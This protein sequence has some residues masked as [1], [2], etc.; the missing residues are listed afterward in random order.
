MR[1]TGK[2]AKNKPRGSPPILRKSTTHTA[3]IYVGLVYSI[4]NAPYCGAGVF[5]L[6]HSRQL[7]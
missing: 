6:G 2:R 1:L 5:T 4:D 7:L 3:S